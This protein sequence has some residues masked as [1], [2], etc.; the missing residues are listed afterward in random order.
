MLPAAAVAAAGISRL[1]SVH[2]DAGDALFVAG[3]FASIWA[4]RFGPH[5]T[6]AGT[7]LMAPLVAV[8]ILPQSGLPGPGTL[9]VAVIGLIASIWVSLFQLLAYRTGLAVPPPAPAV[10]RPPV[11]AG[12]RKRIG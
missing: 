6:R 7:L 11:G 3:M 4:R 5:A 12:A 2:P 8:L 9:W 10:A 1:M